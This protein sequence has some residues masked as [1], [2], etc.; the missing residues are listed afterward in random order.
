M[1]GSFHWI[2]IFRFLNGLVNNTIT[3]FSGQY[4]IPR[5]RHSTVLVHASVSGH[6]ILSLPCLGYYEQCFSGKWEGNL[7][8]TGFIFVGSVPR[9]GPTA[10][11]DSDK[12]FT[13]VF[14]E[15]CSGWHAHHQ[16]A[17]SPTP[18]AFILLL[19]LWSLHQEWAPSSVGLQV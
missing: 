12:E 19:A 18:A 6:R 14:Q 3:I 15:G 10:S 9:R 17:S 1:P 2:N 16:C 8:Y 11:C 13:A 7:C 4:R 5:H